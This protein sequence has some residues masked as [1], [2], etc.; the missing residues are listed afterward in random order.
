MIIV[1]VISV[2]V[3]YIIDSCSLMIKS[4]IPVLGSQG[5]VPVTCLVYFK[6]ASFEF[7]FCVLTEYDGKRIIN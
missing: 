6:L 1:I 3:Y 4:H 5:C 7:E 2:C